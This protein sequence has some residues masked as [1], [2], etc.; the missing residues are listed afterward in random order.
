FVREAPGGTGRNR[1]W[2]AVSEGLVW[3]EPGDDTETSAAGD[4]LTDM[5]LEREIQ[6]LRAARASQDRE[7]VEWR[8]ATTVVESKLWLT[9]EE[10]KLL[11]EQL[12]ELFLTHADRLRDPT[13]RPEGAR[14]MSLVGWMVP[15][16]PVR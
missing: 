4:A 8:E 9:T 3:G 11:S 2:R 1:P 14:L 6:R 7:P 10:A 12:V 5:L 15:N 16:G 13:T